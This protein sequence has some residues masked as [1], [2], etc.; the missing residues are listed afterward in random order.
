MH[1]LT[2]DFYTHLHHIDAFLY[3]HYVCVPCDLN[4]DTFCLRYRLTY[5]YLMYI[6]IHYM[7][8][9]IHVRTLLFFFARYFSAISLQLLQ[10]RWNKS[11]RLPYV[12][13]PEILPVS[14]SQLLT[15]PM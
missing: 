5:I 2:F 11:L 14:Y 15:I 3:T 8:M 10:F 9:Y 1:I 13:L 6:Y 12:T 7:F 4:V